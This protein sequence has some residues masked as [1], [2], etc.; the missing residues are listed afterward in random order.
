M[1][2]EEITTVRVTVEL[3]NRLAELRRGGANPESLEDV[4]WRIGKRELGEKPKKVIA[5]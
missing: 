1:A 4:I 3:R 2:E 5:E